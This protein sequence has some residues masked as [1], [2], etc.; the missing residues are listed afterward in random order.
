MCFQRVKKMREYLKTLLPRCLYS[1]V[2]YASLVAAICGRV[3]AVAVLLIVMI[4]K[5]ADNVFAVMRREK[6][7]DEKNRLAN[8]ETEVKQLN[9]ALSFKNIHK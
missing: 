4:N 5:V 9:L 2:V 7:Q 3:E 8:L 1:V 6:E